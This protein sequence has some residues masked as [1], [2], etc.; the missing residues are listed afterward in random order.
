MLLFRHLELVEAA[1]PALGTQRAGLLFGL[2][3]LELLEPVGIFVSRHLVS[4]HL[5][6]LEPFYF[7]LQGREVVLFC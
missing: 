1:Y 6:E 2:G 4:I 7:L 5:R 3:L